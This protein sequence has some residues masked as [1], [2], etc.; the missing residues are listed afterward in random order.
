MIQ[1]NLGVA[2]SNRLQGDRG[3]NLESAIDHYQQALEIY[4]R[5]AFPIDWAMTQNNLGIAY[6]KRIQGDRSENINHA[7]SYYQQALEVRTWEAFP[8]DWTK[9]LYNLT[10]VLLTKDRVREAYSGIQDI[11]EH[12]KTVIGAWMHADI[13][14][15]G[16][17]RWV[18]A[19]A[20]E[21]SSTDVKILWQCIANIA[22][23]GDPGTAIRALKEIVLALIQSRQPVEALKLLDAL[24]EAHAAN[25]SQPLEALRPV[26]EFAAGNHK[27]LARVRLEEREAVMTLLTKLGYKP[28]APWT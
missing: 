4:S 2:Y 23:A 3:E 17:R 26:A 1:N 24:Q 21:A 22:V 8:M 15:R 28:T 16:L 11:L 27:A 7:I 13:T 14:E 19:A 25:L 20:K 9:S 12:T 18:H 10:L 6:S 5:E